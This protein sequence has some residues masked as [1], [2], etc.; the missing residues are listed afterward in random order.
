MTIYEDQSKP[1][2][3]L[4]AQNG[5]TLL[6]AEEPPG[7]PPPIADTVYDLSKIDH[8]G[9]MAIMLGWG[10]GSLFR[11]LLRQTNSRLTLKQ[12]HW[13][14][15]DC[16][17]HDFAQSLKHKI[18]PDYNVGLTL[19]VWRAGSESD[20]M[21]I[22]HRLSASH[23]GIPLMGSL[24]FYYDH[25]LNT[26]ATHLRERFRPALRRNL[27]ER[28]SMPGN[29]PSD[30]W[31]GIR[32]S[33]LNL[34]KLID[35]P[36]STELD[37]VLN[38]APVFCVGSGPHIQLHVDNLRNVQ[39]RA[40]I[41]CAESAMGA[42]HRAD[43]HPDLV[44]P[45]E[46]V[47]ETVGWCEPAAGTK[48]WFGGI[49]V[50]PPGTLEHFDDRLFLIPGSDKIVD[51]YDPA[52][53]LSRMWTGHTT[54]VLGLSVAR[55]MSLGDI[56]LVGQDLSYGPTGKSHWSEVADYDQ[57]EREYY[58]G[59]PCMVLG[60]CG[61][62]VRSTKIWSVVTSQISEINRQNVE[63]LGLPPVKSIMAHDRMGAVVP[64]LEP[65]PFPDLP[66]I[67][68]IDFSKIPGNPDRKA[69]WLQCLDIL[70]HDWKRAI[71]YF[72]RVLNSA[73]RFGADHPGSWERELFGLAQ[74]INVFGG[75][76]C[77]S[78][79]ITRYLLH[80][81]LYNGALNIQIRRRVKSDYQAKCRIAEGIRC[82]VHDI[83]YLMRFMLPLV[84]DT[85]AKARTM[86]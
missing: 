20:A 5:I 84:E 29:S 76:T 27:E 40:Y 47:D 12:I 37:N 2:L 78:R 45:M 7:L 1:F 43:V 74:A 11:S 16:E 63:T 60:N 53:E 4:A 68:K 56:Y 39:D 54:C 34:P 77:Y 22:A 55:W 9:S 19:A 44:C 83:L 41:I 69:Y 18:T 31:D 62:Y 65:S 58:S 81:A 33:I 67:D 21:G 6:P 85:C 82:M 26:S 50:V 38:N 51:W 10:D 8:W 13:V 71:K 46:R 24:D 64:G 59:E 79:P 42:L 66:K 80:N 14:I 48:T 86:L 52:R 15:F 32:N 35:R 28:L 57:C 36:S 30:A 23:A 49:A 70:P 61:E 75:V 3:A 25:P 72:E 17:L 73:H